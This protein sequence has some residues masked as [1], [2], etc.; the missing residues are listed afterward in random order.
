MRQLHLAFKFSAFMLACTACSSA[1]AAKDIYLTD[2]IKTP[3]YLHALTNLLKGVPSLPPWTKQVLK[4]TGDY[5]GAPVDYL[6]VDGT[7]YT[8]FN[9]CKPHDCSN[10]ALELMFTPNGTQAWGAIVIDGNSVIYLG[11]PSA[12]QQSVLKAPL[13]Q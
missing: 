2:A 6:T 10:N 13:Q 4:T 3:S 9:A 11:A 1:V 7:K 5:V 8:L 12:A